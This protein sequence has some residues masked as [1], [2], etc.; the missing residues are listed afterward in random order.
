MCGIAGKLYADPARRVTPALVDAMTDALAHR[1]P[2][3]RGTHVVGPV[4][5]GHRRLSI[6]DLSPDA[7]QPMLGPSGAAITFNG[8]IYNFAELRRFLEGQGRR[9]ATR[10]DTEVLLAL[11]EHEGERCLER[12]VG[13]FAFAIWDPGRQ[14]LFCARDRLG[15]KPFYYRA[16]GN[17]FA[18]ASE[19]A[20]LLADPEVPRVLDPGALHHYLTLHYAPSPSTAFAGVS[21]LPAAHALTWRAGALR[22]WRYWQPHFEPKHD[23][24]ADE[25]GEELW[26][27]IREA[28]R[29]RMISDVPLG[30]F[31]SGGTDSSAIVAAM[32]ALGGGRIKT[33]SIGF[34]ESEFNELGWAREVAQRYGTDHCELMVTPD[35]A[36]ALPVLVAHHGEPFSDPSSI[37]T[38]YLCKLAREHV[39]VALSGDGGDEAFG[40]YS[41][42]VWAWMAGLLD[43]VPRPALQGVAALA[44]WM[45]ARPAAA[46]SLRLAGQHMAAVIAP[47]TDRYLWMAG[48]F[49]PW[50]RDRLY[51]AEFRARLHAAGAGADTR[52]WFARTE[53]EGDA[54]A[55]LDQYIQNDLQGYLA[56][57]IMT[58]VDIASM[59]H[60]LEVRAPLLDHRIVEFGARLPVDLKQRGLRK[61][62]LFRAAVRPYLPRSVLTRRKRGFGIP[63]A[64]WLRG[65]LREMLEELVGRKL[66]ERGIFA[67]AALRGLVA[68]HVTGRADHGHKLWNLM[69]LELWSARF[70][71]RPASAAGPSASPSRQ[72]AA[73]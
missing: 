6:I 50:E 71:D 54:R 66:G 19:L 55:R 68:E 31:L 53:R 44:R 48:H 10:S 2:D 37:P 15:K 63:V 33:F 43:G 39:T 32:S 7:N 27:L 5:L 38:Y 9:F 1:G 73:G 70:L 12:L 67:P 29:L 59:A 14:T 51:T 57:G 40:G 60:S 47:D 20:G 72:A 23:R 69:V 61:R 17:G 24:G 46:P 56:D 18:F 30:A 4:G 35:A 49:P 52:D 3:A 13:M 36:E 45:G 42:Y 8:E 65:P 11:Y 62:I 16:D 28:T 26:A 41:R 64:A 58:K 25:L 21:K 22:V 34:R